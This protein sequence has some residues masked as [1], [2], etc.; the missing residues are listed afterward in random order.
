[1]NTKTTMQAGMYAPPTCDVIN[2]EL[3]GTVLAASFELPVEDN[4]FID[5]I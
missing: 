5:L 1:M 4:D 2:L 3:D